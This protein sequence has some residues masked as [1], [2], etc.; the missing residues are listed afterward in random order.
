MAISLCNFYVNFVKK[1]H[2]KGYFVSLKF[3]YFEPQTFF[4]V[5]LHLTDQIQQNQPQQVPVLHVEVDPIQIQHKIDVT[6]IMT[7]LF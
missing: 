1:G 3:T 7:Q 2:K 5:H 4:E 6:K